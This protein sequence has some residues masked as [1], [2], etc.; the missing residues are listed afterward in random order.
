MTHPEELLAAYV[1]GTLSPSERTVVVAHLP[2]CMQCREE[3]SLAGSVVPTLA[4]LP[5]V[6]VPLGVSGPVIARARGQATSRVGW[7]LGRVQ[8]AFGFA[9]AAA[10]LLLI[11]VNLPHLGGGDEQRAS[12][13][14]EGGAAAA[15]NASPVPQGF[16]GLEQQSV[17]YDTDSVQALAKSAAGSAKEAVSATDSGATD[18][19]STEAA[20]AAA[21]DQA[22]GCLK[23]SGAQFSASIR[24]VEL[25]DATFRGTPAYLGVFVQGPGA[26]QPADHAVV[27]IVAKQNCSFLTAASQRI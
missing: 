15:P 7:H 18:S 16:V 14:A 10:L 4:S 26:G 21:G 13:P 5:E 22:I 3:I 9:A 20:L 12:S 27:W 24:L 8:W 11:V 19:G 23:Q 2:G 25:I 17:D 1:D 6:P